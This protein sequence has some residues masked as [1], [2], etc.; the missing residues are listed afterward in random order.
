MNRLPAQGC[1]VFVVGVRS[2]AA[3]LATVRQGL[4]IGQHPGHA[5]S[6]P[7]RSDAERLARK[8]SKEPGVAV[9]VLRDPR[10]TPEHPAVVGNA[11][12]YLAGS[13]H[14]LL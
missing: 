5:Y 11:R 3:K 2:L 4:R 6:I 13:F 7:G 10:G 1:V 9:V 12:V 14:E 8:L